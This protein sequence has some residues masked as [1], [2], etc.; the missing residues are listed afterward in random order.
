MAKRIGADKERKTHTLA[1]SLGNQI[2]RLR[3]KRGW[4]QIMLAEVLGYDERYIRQLEQGTKSP[5]LRT[6]VNVAHAFEIPVSTL[7]K[8]A[9]RG[10]TRDGGPAQK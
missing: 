8:R 1:A 5:T 2:T 10:V 9:E 4:S 7:I 6:L 3:P